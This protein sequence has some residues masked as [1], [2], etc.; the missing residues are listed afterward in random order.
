MMLPGVEVDVQRAAEPDAAG[1][2]GDCQI[3]LATAAGDPQGVSSARH[4]HVEL[5]SV[6]CSETQLSHTSTQTHTHT[7]KVQDFFY[8]FLSPSTL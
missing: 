7:N 8:F 6:S 1:V 4:S 2:S 3:F 5:L